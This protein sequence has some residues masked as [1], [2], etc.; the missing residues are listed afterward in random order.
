MDQG[1]EPMDGAVDGGQRQGVPATARV[2]PE[3]AAAAP[4]QGRV[5]VCVCVC[6]ANTDVGTVSVIY[7]ITGAV[8]T[9]INDVG[10]YPEGVAA[11]TDGTRVYVADTGGNTVS[12]ID[13]GSN[14]VTTTIPVGA[15]PQGAAVHPIST[16]AYVANTGDTDP[17]MSV[18]VLHTP[19][20]TSTVSVGGGP[21]AVATAVG[22]AP[23]PPR[24]C[25]AEA[26]RLVSRRSGRDDREEG[27]SRGRPGGATL[28][29]RDTTRGPIPRRTR[30]DPAR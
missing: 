5:C 3:P 15:S 11:T 19:I 28:A 8:V 6:V 30:T 27:Q 18:A 21:T 10:T 16:R 22:G 17:D 4:G 29:R 7:T 12:A 24:R 26:E 20:P 14:T 25:A 13:T 23:T 9:T 1:P 2:S